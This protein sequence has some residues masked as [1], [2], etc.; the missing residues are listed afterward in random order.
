VR[1][2]AGA[3]ACENPPIMGFATQ[4]LFIGAALPALLILAWTMFRD[5][6]PE[7]PKVVFVTFL[8]SA[9]TTIPILIVNL[10]LVYAFGFPER[11]T[12]IPEAM[13]VSFVS[14][15]LVEEC[16]K[17]AVLRGYAARHDAFDEPY[18]GIVYGVAASLGFAFVENLL[19]VFMYSE[20]FGGQLQ[21]AVLR[22]VLSVPLHANCGALMGFAIGIARF[23]RGPARAGW[24]LL[25]L[26]GAILLHGTYNSFA[27]AAE[28]TAIAERNLGGACFLAAVLVAAVGAAV[29]S[30]A[31]ARL[32]RDQ[33]L[34]RAVSTVR[35]ADDATRG[36][37]GRHEIG[38]HGTAWHEPGRDAAA[39]AMP[40]P[41]TASTTRVR[42]NATPALPIAA[43]TLAAIAGI[44]FV[45]SFLVAAI[46][47]SQGAPEDSPV[48]VAVGAGML[49][50]LGGALAGGVIAIVAIVLRRPW[51]AA[52]IA[53]AIVS[54]VVVAA[55]IA[56]V[57]IGLANGG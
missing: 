33:M 5:R 57:A 34:W 50:A 7:P 16:F 36:E 48:L 21:T 19:Y 53:A 40:A 14:A 22:A 42:S 31:A 30:L 9:L 28:T 29:A 6:L 11:P 3:V 55:G 43:L 25:G 4:V 1:E 39:G 37:T 15:A 44:L 35:A 26:G 27:F 18:D 41:G 47:G 46:A 24:T 8:L 13:L 17:F 52:S 10:V 51:L 2:H 49:L 32:R 12:T 20:S 23:S 38:R 45:A 54:A 56:L